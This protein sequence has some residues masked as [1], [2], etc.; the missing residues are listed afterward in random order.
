MEIYILK[1]YNYLTNNISWPLHFHDVKVA[2]VGRKKFLHKYFTLSDAPGEGLRLL[3]K[4]GS[5]FSVFWVNKFLF[6]GVWK[7][8]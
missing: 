2:P 3:T 7:K 6:L 4:I 8:T 1:V 5:S